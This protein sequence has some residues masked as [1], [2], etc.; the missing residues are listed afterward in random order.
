[1]GKPSITGCTSS[2]FLA[3]SSPLPDDPATLEAVIDARSQTELAIIELQAHGNARPY[4]D[5]IERSPVRDSPMVKPAF[6]VARGAEAANLGD[7]ALGEKLAADGYYAARAVDDDAQLVIA[8]TVLLRFAN[9]KPPG[10]PMVT[11]WLRIASAD[12]DRIANRLPGPAAGLF[13]SAAIVSDRNDDGPAALRYVARARAL[14][15]TDDNVMSRSSVIEGNV[16]MWG[17]HVPEGIAAY[18][19]GIAG[20]IKR[21]GPDHPAVG[22]ILT[23]YSA[24]LLD[25]RRMKEAFEVARRALTILE[26]STDAN[27]QVA[28]NARVNLAAVLVENSQNAEGL[29]LLETARSHYVAHQ[30]VKSSVVANIDMNLAIIHLDAHDTGKAIALLEEALATD[31]ALHGPERIET[32]EVLYN[33]AVARRDAKDLER[34]QADADRCAA[35]YAKNRPGVDRHI[36]ALG[37]VAEIANL[38]ADHA[39]ALTATG[40]ALAFPP[41]E[42]SQS[43]AWARL[44]RGRALIALHRSAEARPLL[45]AARTGYQ[46]AELPERVQEIDRLL[47][48]T[49]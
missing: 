14:A 21:F 38:R 43:S 35:I 27:D 47:A 15:P 40:I 6:L 7:D 10:E 20:E 1:M 32:A 8:L 45:V 41:H 16:L 34:A 30:G 5:R 17:G 49:R 31:E 4:L 12:A 28:D 42:D 18:E 33:L 44:E 39:K 11:A 3:A 25:A 26:K 19:R 24:S 29:R 37:L 2:S 23:D 48:Q 13:L 9:E 22:T 36:V 46:A